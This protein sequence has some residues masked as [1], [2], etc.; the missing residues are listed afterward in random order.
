MKIRP[1]KLAE[2]NSVYYASMRT[3]VPSQA[4]VDHPKG[5]QF[6]V[7]VTGEIDLPGHTLKMRATIVRY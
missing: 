4:K 5:M 7:Q 1:P 2:P 6:G 3:K